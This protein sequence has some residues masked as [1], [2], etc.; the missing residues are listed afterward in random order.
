MAHVKIEDRICARVPHDVYELLSEAANSIG[1]T[2]NQFLVQ[3]AVEKAHT[4]V[5]RERVI[6]LSA[7]AA[8]T[9]FDL[10]DNPPE[11]NEQLI[12]A[13][14]RREEILCRQ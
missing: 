13:M 10:L 6:T 5:E 12:K 2:I 11:P 7:K 3:S 14:Q 8:K 9:V 1:A 4:I